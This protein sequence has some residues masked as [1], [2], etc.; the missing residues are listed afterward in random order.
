MENSTTSKASD[1]DTINEFCRMTATEAVS[2][3]RNRDITPLEL[4]EAS[5]ERIEMVDRQVNALPIRRFDKA[6]EE[7]RNWDADAH[8]GNPKSLY[9]LPIAV[10]DYNQQEIPFEYGHDDEAVRRILSTWIPSARTAE[11][12][13]SEPDERGVVTITF[14]EKAAPKG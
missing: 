1:L 12:E 10:K 6:R 7:A 9:G 5:I 8:S 3:L 4:V 14:R 13:R 11:L 2:R